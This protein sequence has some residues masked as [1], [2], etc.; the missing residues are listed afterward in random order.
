MAKQTVDTPPPG[1]EPTANEVRAALERILHSRCFEHA[2]R[3]SDFLRFV[4]GQTV[5]GVGERL[6]GYT[7]AVEVFGRSPDFDAQSDPLVR[8]EAL[9]L[10]QRLT[11]Y[12]AGEGAGDPVKLD[13]PRGGYAVKA[14][15]ANN[16]PLQAAADA[17]A[18]LPA[19]RRLSAL[20]DAH[21]RTA[22]VAAALL[23][24]AATAVITVQWQASMA[25]QAQQQDR[26][27]ERAHRTKIAVVPLENLSGTPDFDR[28]AAG[29][30]EEIMLRL[31][32]LDL[33]VIATQAKWYGPGAPLDGMLGTEHSYVLTGSVRDQTAGVRI[34]VR[35]IEAKTGAQIWST[36]YDEPPS[37]EQQP[38]LQGKIARDVAAA[39]APFGP[40]FDAELALARRT[41]HQ[42]ELPDC[43]TR[44]RAFRRATDP[45]LFPEAFA[46][47]Q[48]VVQRRPELSQ[49]WAGLAMVF[50]DEHMFHEGDGESLNRARAAVATA[51]RLDGTN[52]LANA[53]L[54]RI[55][56]YSGDPEFVSTAER[57]LALDPRNPEMLGLLGILLAAYGDPVHGTELIAQ[58]HALS[59][60]PRPMFN[61]GLVFAYLQEDNGCA[62]LPVAK[63]L[64]APKWFIA[65]M[66][67][68]AAAGLC[69][70]REAAAD[71]RLRLL[72]ISPRFETE[73]R[74][75]I[76]VWR[77]DPRLRA[78]LTRG[79]S[80]AGFHVQDGP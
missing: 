3:A 63:G 17:S 27:P 80:K 50:V 75:L 49:A 21:A 46:C 66:V 36:A 35:I 69:G 18:S 56:Y 11:E 7:I 1:A 40:V 2:G 28:L 20:L 8:V 78:A 5:A 33:F 47:F 62:A 67:T 57:T 39:A 16:E 45:A 22:S 29:L 43:Q 54:T 58:A 4:V 41:A 42:L 74:A 55:Q 60:Q 53:A 71:A 24:M 26:A 70:D 52:L 19:A 79:L 9:R 31:D 6:K 15:Y 73:F 48:S 38:A 65:P 51:L 37:I 14:S 61:L 30:T 32:D 13:L 10:R 23:L 77:F 64:D 12:Y 76:E 44:Y 25:E 72:A 59:P 68:A 34:T